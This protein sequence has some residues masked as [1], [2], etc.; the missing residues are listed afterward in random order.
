MIILQIIAMIGSGII[1]FFFGS[2]HEMRKCALFVKHLKD[3]QREKEEAWGEHC[4]AL[5]ENYQNALIEE[6]KKHGKCFH[7]EK[8]RYQGKY[9]VDPCAYVVKEKYRNV[10]IEISECKKCGHTDV[11]WIRQEDTEEVEVE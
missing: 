5:R 10:T 3:E 2:Q 7:T 9:E 6:R 8:V 1:G 11:S 4:K